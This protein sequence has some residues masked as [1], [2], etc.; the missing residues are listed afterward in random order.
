VIITSNAHG[1]YGV[2]VKAGVG[3]AVRAVILQ[4]PTVCALGTFSWLVELL[5]PT[6]MVTGEAEQLPRML[7]FTPDTVPLKASGPPLVVLN[8]H[9]RFSSLGTPHSALEPLTVAPVIEALEPSAATEP[10][11]AML[12][13]TGMPNEAGD[14][15]VMEPAVENDAPAGAIVAALAIETAPKHIANEVAQTRVFKL[16]IILPHM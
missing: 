2:T 15:T 8:V 4:E 6:L 14:V 3:V 7:K 13:V 16:F 10:V 11:K 1:I 12:Q 5:K 9:G